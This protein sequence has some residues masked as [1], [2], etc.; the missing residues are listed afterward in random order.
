MTIV[1]QTNKSENNKIGKTLTNVA[2]L[3]GSLR[4][5]SSIIDPVIIIEADLS[6][7]TGCNYMT[8]PEFGRSYFVTDLISVQ[9]GIVEVHAHVDV[10][11]SYKTQILAQKAIVSRNQNKYNLMLDTKYKKQA[12]SHSVIKV[13]PHGFTEKSS[14]VLVWGG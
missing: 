9:N 8:I 2:T 1:L 6:T 12:D 3:T 5:K 4:N 11:E 14:W 10:L 7:L 13:F